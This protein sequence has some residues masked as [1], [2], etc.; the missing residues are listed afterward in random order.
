MEVSFGE[1]GVDTAAS[2]R[3]Q[4]VVAS[5]TTAMATLDATAAA[6]LFSADGVVEDLALRSQIRGRLAVERY[7]GRALAELPYG[8]E[9]RVRHILGSDEGGGYEWTR[10]ARCA[11]SRAWSSMTPVRSPA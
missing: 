3:V 7:F 10:G 2:Q 4:R 11:A 6:A 8:A 1:E 5:L 9:V